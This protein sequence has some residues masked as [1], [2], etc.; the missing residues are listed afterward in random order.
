MH[1]NFLLRFLC[2]AFVLFLSVG[3]FN[4]VI[5]PYSI[6][7]FY[8]EVGVNQ[9]SPKADDLDRLIKPIEI[10]KKK[11][12][13]IFLGDSQVL[14]G[15]DAATYTGATGKSAYNY[16]LRGATVYELRRS[17]EHVADVDDSL[18][19][20]Y[21]NVNFSMFSYSANVPGAVSK[22]G[23]DE[24]QIGKGYVSLKN[25]E[26]TIFSWQALLDSFETIA[27]NRKNRYE[28]TSYTPEGKPND[29]SIL[30]YYRDKPQPFY[31]SFAGDARA[32][33]Y[34]GELHLYEEA[35]AELQRIRQICYDRQIRLHLI[36]LPA[37]GYALELF[38]V[39]S[40]I[41]AEFLQRVVEIAPVTSFIGYDQYS[42]S[43]LEGPSWQAGGNEYFWDT[44]HIKSEVG[45]K[46]LKEL[47]DGAQAGW[48]KAI[49]REN[50]AAYLQSLQAGRVAWNAS[51][52]DGVEKVRYYTG[53]SPVPPAAALGRTYVSG[54]SV[55]RLDQGSGTEKLAL[56]V[57]RQGLL[58]VTGESLTPIGED[59][60]MYAVLENAEGKRY[61][62]LAEPAPNQDIA[63]FMHSDAYRMSGFHI[64]E[65]LRE[66]EPGSYDLYLL[67]ASSAGEVYK[68]ASLAAVNVDQR[69]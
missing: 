9:W 1:R 57:S 43:K 51:N 13:V 42:Q 26:K 34:A 55:V 27:A 60:V 7:N 36:S 18:T 20:V 47:A 17:L 10:L 56:S 6:W 5:D 62:T 19:D 14:W 33:R 40:P 69:P 39:T 23:F 25:I 2:A 24:G 66:V 52:P 16:G 38:D 54:K 45:D 59:K 4:C 67:E 28:T 65:S 61:Y 64:L 48:G 11:P 3:M 35:F 15:L 31:T 12:Q 41:Y 30:S 63:G 58:D 50:I 29:F 21:L 68:S 44:H 53:F 49:S 46:L 37:H 22:P 32:G 8:R